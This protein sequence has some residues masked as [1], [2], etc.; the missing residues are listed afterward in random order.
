MRL[1]QLLVWCVIRKLLIVVVK[2]KILFLCEGLCQPWLH[3][4]CAGLSSVRFAQLC[5][6]REPIYCPSCMSVK[7]SNDLVEAN[8]VLASMALEMEQLRKALEGTK[9]VIRIF[10][11]CRRL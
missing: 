2:A 11:F 8:N 5:N 10:P 1:R 6:D 9:N 7:L 3:R 4:C